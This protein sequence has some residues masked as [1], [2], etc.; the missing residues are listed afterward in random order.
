MCFHWCS[1]CGMLQTGMGK[2]KQQKAFFSFFNS[3]LPVRGISVGVYSFISLARLR[4]VR[5]RLP[6]L[7][8]LT[9]LLSGRTGPQRLSCSFTPPSLPRSL[10]PALPPSSISLS[11]AQVL[12][13]NNH[14][15]M[16][17]FS[18]PLS[19]T[20]TLLCVFA[21]FS[22]N[23]FFSPSC[24]QSFTPSFN[25]FCCSPFSAAS[26]SLYAVRLC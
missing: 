26:L 7:L 17:P 25:S 11:L 3:I 1:T 24:F 14:S 22:F 5:Q 8:L 21:I 23:L 12:W 15:S 16:R 13:E 19:D 18:C 9:L 20:D 4:P 6:A 2:E 10:L